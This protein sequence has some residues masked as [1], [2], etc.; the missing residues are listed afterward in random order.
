M[1]DFTDAMDAAHRLAQFM[2]SQD[3]SDD[4]GEVLGS[5][6]FARL[7]RSMSKSRR[8]ASNLISGFSM[9]SGDGETL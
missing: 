4:S 1:F 2:I 7:V 9:F 8:F 5:C 3:L 6:C